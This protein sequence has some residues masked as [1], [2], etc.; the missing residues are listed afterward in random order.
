MSDLPQ[1]TGP[2]P[3]AIDVSGREAG[4]QPRPPAEAP[5]DPP[6]TGPELVEEGTRLVVGSAMLVGRMLR[7]M[8]DPN[9]SASNGHAD[10]ASDGSGAPT[11][12]GPTDERPDTVLA[13]MPTALLGWTMHTQRRALN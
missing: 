3:A 13:A 5:A 6:M 12:D 9:A 7:Q 1:R 8:I 11:E 10:D 2:P 4:V